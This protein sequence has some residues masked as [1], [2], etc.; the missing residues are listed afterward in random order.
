MQI[1]CVVAQAK[2]R[3]EV[4]AHSIREPL[5]EEV[6]A[7][8]LFS[9]ISP[10]TELRCLAG[11]E[12]NAGA[13]PMITGYSLVA[14]VVRPAGDLRKGEMVF[15]NGTP[16]CPQGV[17]LS[18]GGHVSHVV[19]P[20]HGVEP[21]AVDVWRQ[22][23]TVFLHDGEFLIG[24]EA[25]FRPGLADEIALLDA[26]RELA[27]GQVLDLAHGQAFFPAVQIR[28]A[29]TTD[30]ADAQL[31]V[32]TAGSKQRPDESRLDL[33]QRNIKITNGI[34]DEIVQQ[35]SSA[36]ALMVSN[37]VDILTY[38]AYKR[39]GW[40]RGRARREPDRNKLQPRQ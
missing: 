33:L 1:Q 38:A 24:L 25:A 28:V 8:T 16:L 15:F 29:E 31:I 23:C 17:S 12:H 32:I 39:S 6:V 4:Q 5:P 21:L 18:W 10:G 19:A 36:V 26:N 9:A 37:P 14:K 30:Y 3:V 22:Q 27:M 34:I 20:Q 13:F 40:P 11:N 35:K 2:N 7:E